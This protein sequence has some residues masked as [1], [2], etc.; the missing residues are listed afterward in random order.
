MRMLQWLSRTRTP[1]KYLII[2]VWRNQNSTVSLPNFLDC[3]FSSSNH[4][5]IW[6]LFLINPENLIPDHIL[7]FN[8]AWRLSVSLCINALRCLKMNQYWTGLFVSYLVKNPIA[9]NYVTSLVLIFAFLIFAY[10]VHP[11]DPKQLTS[12]NV[13]VLYLGLTLYNFFYISNLRM[14]IISLSVC[15]GKPLPPSLMF[16]GKARSPH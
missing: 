3:P 8:Q 1:P 5:P 16:V 15:P 4:K 10:L 12:I 11:N 6:P 7:T 9:W 2:L 13:Y 14:F